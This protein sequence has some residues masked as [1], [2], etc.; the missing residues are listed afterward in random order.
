MK[1]TSKEKSMSQKHILETIVDRLVT[2]LN[3]YFTQ[4][5]KKQV[6]SKLP[7]LKLSVKT[8]IGYVL[9][10]ENIVSGQGYASIHLSP[11]WYSNSTRYKTKHSYRIFVQR[12]YRGL[13]HLGYLSQAKAGVSH[14]SRGLYL[15]RY[16]AT[17]KL[18]KLFDSK[19]LIELP[20]VFAGQ[21]E[22][23]EII[24]VQHT[25]E[26]QVPL[27]EVDKYGQPKTRTVKY[28]ELVEYEDTDQ[29]N[30][31]RHN[32]QLINDRIATKWVDLELS[33]EE[34][35]D[36]VAQMAKKD[37][38]H[39]EESPDDYRP[40]MLSKRS[41]YRVFND[42]EFQTG[43]RFYGGWWQE[44]PSKFRDRIT[45]DGKRTVQ[46]DYSGLHPHILYHERGL[47]LEGDPYQVNLIP[48]KNAE[49]TDGF[50]KFI[51]QCFNAMLNATN[52]MKRAP[53]GSKLGHWGVTWKQAVNAIKDRHPD[54]EDQ[55]FTGAG[56]RLQRIDSDLCEAV[57]LAM[58][59]RSP[60]IVILPVH[61]SF[62]VHHGYKNEL[63][64]MMIGAYCIKYGS[65]PLPK[66]SKEMV[67]EVTGVP[68]WDSW[69]ARPI[70]HDNLADLLE[71]AEMV[72]SE[73]RLNLFC[74]GSR[75]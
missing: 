44:L 37:K 48:R 58:I 45:I 63:M 25:H 50:R 54:I 29:T 23:S 62:I 14:G 68:E 70:D 6:K 31:M 57:M 2:E 34:H 16:R 3:T 72:P 24:R 74:A 22:V 33:K 52:E 20:V 64:A 49:D 47:E 35:I 8:L 69:S 38:E 15:T 13:I 61:D 4:V 18:L 40:L 19:S 75:L 67:V 7:N 21:L 12:A 27:K 5:G 30:Q 39:L 73:R 11:N 65:I 43:G 28:R 17:P 46:L 71:L 53:R 26:E 42:T 56:L 59:N 60:E 55:F 41:L 1:T 51:K 9:I 32:L 36:L 10:S 66:T